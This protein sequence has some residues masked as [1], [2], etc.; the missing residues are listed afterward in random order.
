MK[1]LPLEGQDHKAGITQT[2]G[3]LKCHI[4]HGSLEFLVRSSVKT[5]DNIQPQRPVIGNQNSELA[6]GM[7][8]SSSQ[9]AALLGRGNYDRLTKSIIFHASN[10][11]SPK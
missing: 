7:A 2:Q 4:L 6:P 9:R 3:F 11:L 10:Y 8:P 1:T 5:E